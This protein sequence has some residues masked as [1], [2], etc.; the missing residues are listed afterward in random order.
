MKGAHYKRRLDQPSPHLA[1]SNELVDCL[2]CRL[3]SDSEDEGGRGRVRLRQAKG[4]IWLDKFLQHFKK[5]H[6]GDMP[7]EG[8]SLLDMGFTSDSVRPDQLSEDAIMETEEEGRPTPMAQASAI[9][10]ARTMQPPPRQATASPLFLL[11]SLKWDC[12]KGNHF[13][14]F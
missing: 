13:G 9:F 7:S 5:I 2:F 4:G 6:K 8:M 14:G 3:P 12:S 10:T 1:R 11:L